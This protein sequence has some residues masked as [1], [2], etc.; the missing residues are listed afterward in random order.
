MTK[1]TIAIVAPG[2]MGHAV[3]RALREHGHDA[4]TCLAGRSERSRKLAEA[5]G[6]RDVAD[7]QALVTEADLFLSILP[8]ASALGLAREVAAAMTESGNRLTYVDCNAISPETAK[9]VAAVIEATGAP[10]IDA[11]IIGLAP[12]KGKPRFYVSGPD[13]SLMEALDG[14]GF[15]IKPSGPEAGQA[16]AIKMC[17]AALTKGTWTLH[18]ALLMAA[19]SLGVYD[20]LIAEFE[21]SQSADLARMEVRIPFIPADSGRWVGE[22]EEI[23]A[24]FREAGVTGG[25]HDG[26]AE[27]FRVLSRTPFAEETRESLDRNRGLEESVA[28]FVEHLDKERN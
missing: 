16:S 23:A 12:G 1:M 17:Y 6:L 25:F 11:G 26:A 19:R 15:E 13:T 7:M 21:H 3:G 18:T 4:I 24:T 20:T 22:M 9:Q 2:D 28:V 8:P 5:G 14:C 27:V 10:F